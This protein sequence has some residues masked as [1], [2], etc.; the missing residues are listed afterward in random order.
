MAS[1]GIVQPATFG[2]QRVYK[3]AGGKDQNRL[4]DMEENLR[5]I[6]KFGWETSLDKY[7]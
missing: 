4:F 6:S 1:S 2:Y 7:P 5:Y 3:T